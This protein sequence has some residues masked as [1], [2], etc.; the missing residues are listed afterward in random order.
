[1][2]TRSTLQEDI[3]E[4]VGKLLFRGQKILGLGLLD[5]HHPK[6]SDDDDL[7]QLILPGLI[8]HD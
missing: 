7:R 3:A 5:Q 8:L 4:T 1:M 6:P 2:I